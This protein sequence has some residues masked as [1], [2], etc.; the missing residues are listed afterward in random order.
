M[1]RSGSRGREAAARAAPLPR[2]PAS[3]QS[4]RRFGYL[5][6][7]GTI[8][9][10]Q[11]L[12]VAGVPASFSLWRQ[13]ER[14]DDDITWRVNLDCTPTDN[15]L[16]YLSATKGFSGR[17]LQ[18]GVLQ[19]EPRVQDGKPDLV[20]VGLQRH[21]ARRHHAV[22]LGCLLTTTTRTSRP[23]VPALGLQPGQHVDQRVLG[24]VRADRRLGYR[25]R[26]ADHRQPHAGR[27]L[28]LHAQRIHRQLRWST[29]R[30]I[31]TG[32]RRCSTR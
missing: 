32:H 6:A 21:V 15:D 7:D 29:I 5:A 31:R 11:R 8:L 25:P 10:P 2:R 3:R 4:T 27:E 17:W 28:Q 18:P 12:L 19:C 30:T 13:E 14:K 24:A 9:N 16:I 20:R 22:E 1:T 23:S 26:L